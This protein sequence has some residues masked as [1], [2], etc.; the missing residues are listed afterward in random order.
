MAV[1]LPETRVALIIPRS[2]VVYTQP[3][4]CVARLVNVHHV[5]DEAGNGMLFLSY[6]V[7]L[8]GVSQQDLDAIDQ[9]GREEVARYAEDLGMQLTQDMSI[10][11]D[12]DTPSSPTTWSEKDLVDDLFSSY[13][14]D[15]DIS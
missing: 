2:L 3:E 15:E 9:V 5:T 6:A 8:Y 7:S 4:E 11:V 10:H 12:D 1:V 14:D 13:L